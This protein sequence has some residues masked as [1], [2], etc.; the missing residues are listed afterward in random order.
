LEGF[1][2]WQGPKALVAEANI[3]AF[4]DS[5]QSGKYGITEEGGYSKV[6]LPGITVIESPE[7]Q[8][9]NI[10]GIVKILEIPALGLNSVDVPF[11]KIMESR[12]YEFVQ[13]PG[14]TVLETPD[15]NIVNVFGIN[16]SE[17]NKQLVASKISQIAEDQRRDAT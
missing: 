6:R 17:G 1:K 9:V 4:L 11:V 8:Y 10:M 14:F 12:D 15:G 3:Q 5:V 7:I 2:N 16:F 13:G